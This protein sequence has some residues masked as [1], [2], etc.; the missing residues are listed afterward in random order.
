MDHF[1]DILHSNA[2]W[3]IE[4]LTNIGFNLLPLNVVNS[5][6]FKPN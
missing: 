4:N 6:L 5:K 3:Q 2:F 1:K